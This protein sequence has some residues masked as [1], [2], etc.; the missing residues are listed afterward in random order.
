MC[1]CFCA[2]THPRRRHYLVIELCDT[3]V[4]NI[5]IQ[6][7]GQYF[8]CLCCSRPRVWLDTLPGKI[9]SPASTKGCTTYKS[10]LNIYIWGMWKRWV[11]LGVRWKV[12][13]REQVNDVKNSPFGVGALGLVLADM[14]SNKYLHNITWEEINPLYVTTKFLF[15]SIKRLDVEGYTLV[16]DRQIVPGSLYNV[17]VSTSSIKNIK[18]AKLTEGTEACIC[19]KSRS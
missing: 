13:M 19:R 7:L 16:I 10:K 1:V 2:N 4:I 18:W 15:K 6:L 5:C 12:G 9:S 3:F 14:E 8:K 11:G 17:V